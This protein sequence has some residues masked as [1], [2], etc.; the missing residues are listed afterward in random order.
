MRQIVPSSAWGQWWDTGV[1]SAAAAEWPDLRLDLALA[2]SVRMA[3]DER[4]CSLNCHRVRI[5]WPLASLFA[6][7]TNLF[8]RWSHDA[9]LPELSDG[10][11]P[12]IDLGIDGLCDVEAMDDEKDIDAYVAAGDELARVVVDDQEH[13][14]GAQTIDL[15]SVLLAHA[16]ERSW[17]RGFNYGIQG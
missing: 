7:T 16:L 11:V 10:R 6:A 1:A 13:R 15:G 9:P 12:V 17:R 3:S 5:R 14:D 4:P 8:S 2:R